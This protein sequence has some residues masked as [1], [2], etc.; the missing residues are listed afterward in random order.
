MNTRFQW[1]CFRCQVLGTYGVRG[2]DP[3]EPDDWHQL[4]LRAAQLMA[5]LI[6]WP[7]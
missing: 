2:L 1:C 4:R 6:H 7:W 3:E 5:L